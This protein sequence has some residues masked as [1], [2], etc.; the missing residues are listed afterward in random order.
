M[1]AFGLSQMRGEFRYSGEGVGNHLNPILEGKEMMKDE[2]LNLGITCSFTLLISNKTLGYI[3][4][5]YTSHFNNLLRDTPAYFMY[6]NSNNKK[7]VIVC[8]SAR[9]LSFVLKEAMW[10]F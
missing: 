6:I 9:F 10:R 2:G 1:G 7:S 3:Y 8:L 5:A 4:Y